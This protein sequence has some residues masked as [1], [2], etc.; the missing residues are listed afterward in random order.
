MSSSLAG[1]KIV[2]LRAYDDPKNP[3]RS[4]YALILPATVL[5]AVYDADTGKTLAEI[6]NELTRRVEAAEKRAGAAYLTP[7][8]EEAEE[9]EERT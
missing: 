5:N 8:A 2:E 6:L 1:G 7:P 3:D 9:Q 4:I